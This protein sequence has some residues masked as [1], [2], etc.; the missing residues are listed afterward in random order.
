MAEQGQY[1]VV[2]PNV[3]GTGAYLKNWTEFILH[4]KV[5][6]VG[7]SGEEEDHPRGR[8]MGQMFAGIGDPSVQLGDTVLIA[9]RRRW[10]P[11]VVAVGVICSKRKTKPVPD[12]NWHYGSKVQMRLLNHFRDLTE[13]DCKAIEEALDKVLSGQ[14]AIRLLKDSREGKE[15]RLWLDQ[16]LQ[17]DNQDEDDD[18][19]EEDGSSGVRWQPDLETRYKVEQAAYNAV[20]KHYRD[21]GYRFAYDARKDGCG[22]DLVF[23]K[24]GRDLK[25]EV[26]GLKGHNIVTELTPK[27]YD[28][29]KRGDSGF[30]LCI[31]T[32][33]LKRRPKK[34]THEFKF[35][36]KKAAWF[37]TTDGK[38]LRV[39]PRPGAVVKVEN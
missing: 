5:A 31:V 29:V 39:D 33:A 23:T 21:Q 32:D 17:V 8:R 4:K 2:S 16:L 12:D 25:V 7:W 15:V 34:H 27:E 35:D 22:Y 26:K 6:I 10:A 13:V 9:H 1:W 20:K 37:D 18:E 14:A 19:D 3:K 36:P 30:R 38:K 11:N 28:F 24:N